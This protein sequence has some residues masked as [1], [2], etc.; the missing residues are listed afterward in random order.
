MNRCANLREEGRD[1]SPGSRVRISED[2]EE[3]SPETQ[4]ETLVR[5]AH[6]GQEGEYIEDIVTQCKVRFAVVELA[7]GTRVLI[8]KQYLDRLPVRKEATTA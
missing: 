4:D 7:D 2:A 8:R 3:D 6:A 1:I 5:S